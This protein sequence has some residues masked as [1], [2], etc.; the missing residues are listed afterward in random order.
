MTIMYTYPQIHCGMISTEN[1]LICLFLPTM[2]Y[3]FVKFILGA[4]VYPWNM[5]T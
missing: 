3:A 2:G 4:I 1:F 5:C